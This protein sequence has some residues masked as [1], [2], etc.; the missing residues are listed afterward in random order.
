METPYEVVVAYYEK[1]DQTLVG[2]WKGAKKA[3]GT[4]YPWPTINL[5]RTKRIW[6]E[7]MRFGFVMNVE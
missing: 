3:D 1:Y 7:Y 2:I 6:K 4:K 5:F